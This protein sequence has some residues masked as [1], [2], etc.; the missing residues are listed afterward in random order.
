[1]FLRF[2]VLS[3]LFSVFPEGGKSATTDTPERINLKCH[4]LDAG[5]KS[6]W[7]QTFNIEGNE[8]EIFDNIFINSIKSKNR[9]KEKTIK[10]TDNRIWIQFRVNQE[11][12]KKVS[13]YDTSEY[14][15][16][17]IEI[18]RYTG[19]FSNNNTY[20]FPAKSGGYTTEEKEFNGIC[21]KIDR[22]F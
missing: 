21:E 10:I 14:I 13:K 2:I 18:N 22:K 12:P 1:M 19:E 9:V 17:T 11:I 15:T 16:E 4:F 6:V 20:Y 7:S 3:L 5:K 8:F